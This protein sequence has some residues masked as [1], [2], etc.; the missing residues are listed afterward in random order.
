MVAPLHEGTNGGWGR[1]EQGDAVLLDDLP[2]AVVAREVGHALVHHL[3]G[4]VGQRAIHDV[5]VTRDPANIGGAPIDIGVGVKVEDIL[6]GERCLGEIATAGVH[7][8][9]GPT[10]GAAGVQQEQQLL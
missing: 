8:A 5:G 7:D 6:V 9:L 10:C 3:G 4:T 1:I 2:H